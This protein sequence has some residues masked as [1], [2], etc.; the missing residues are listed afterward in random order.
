MSEQAAH[1]P[2]VLVAVSS[3][4]SG[5]EAVRRGVREARQRQ[6][7]LRLIRVWRNID[8]FFSMSRAE[9]S[10]LRGEERAEQAILSDAA[11]RAAQLDPTLDVEAVLLCGDLYDRLLSAAEDVDLLVVGAGGVGNLAERSSFIGEWFQQH[12]PCPVAIVDVPFPV[13]AHK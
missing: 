8:R 6:G 10:A 4:P 12:A 9:V 1:R 2:T 7:R 5:Q 13:P 11:E 3:S